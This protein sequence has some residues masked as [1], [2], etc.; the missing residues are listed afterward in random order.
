MIVTMDGDRLPLALAPQM[1]LRALVDAAAAELAPERLIVAVA[2]DG[3]NL[4]ST[5][6]EQAL[7][8]PLSQAAQVDLC[9]SD[10]A[11]LAGAALRE[12]ASR[13]ERVGQE[14]AEVA[15]AI[16]TGQTDEALRRFAPFLATWQ[17]AQETIQQCCEVLRSDLTQR[18]IEG[19]SLR[20]HLSDL[21]GKLR[22]L[23]Q[24]LTAGDMVLLADLLEYELAPLCQ[25]W[26]GLLAALAE[27][28]GRGRTPAPAP[29][30]V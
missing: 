25:R 22:E 23:R 6:L 24:A 14:Q 15:A 18:S 11:E 29:A 27:D 2:R 17:A 19:R 3:E 8:E 12:T 30:S 1:T 26:R 7:L 21:A 10:R 4:V 5:A 16:N 28:V 9:T 13:L 20:E